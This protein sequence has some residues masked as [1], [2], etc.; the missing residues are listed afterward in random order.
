VKDGRLVY[1]NGG[2]CV[3]MVWSARGT[4]RL[5]MPKGMLV[6]A[7]SG[8]RYA[9]AECELQVGETLFCY[10]DGVTEAEDFAGTQVS[11]QGCLEWLEH[12]AACDLPALLDS[13][14]ERLVA[15]TGSKLLADDCTMLAVRRLPGE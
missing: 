15:H 14:F 12:E 10:S 1:S 11:E 3:P 9:S 8:R 13:V 6:G 7:A 4:R 5:P 2:H